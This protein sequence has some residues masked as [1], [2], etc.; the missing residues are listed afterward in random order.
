MTTTH[1]LLG[2]VATHALTILLVL[3]PVRYGGQATPWWIDLVLIVAG[4]ACALG[5][6]A[7]LLTRPRSP[8]PNEH[9]VRLRAT[10]SVYAEVDN[11]LDGIGHSVIL[12]VGDLQVVN[13][14][15]RPFELMFTLECPL[16]VVGRP[17]QCEL[18]RANLASGGELLRKVRVEPLSSLVH[19]M[20][21]DTGFSRAHFDQAQPGLLRARLRCCDLLTQ[22]SV[23]VDL[24]GE[25]VLKVSPAPGEPSD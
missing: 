15:L 18:G 17:V 1:H 23:R 14:S 4:A 9:R 7:W 16:L 21:F 2:R 10:R 13:E 12:V 11:P 6:V 25:A 19:S 24:P 22:C 8:E 20:R 3:I 5:S